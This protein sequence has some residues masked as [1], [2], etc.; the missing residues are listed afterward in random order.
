VKRLENRIDKIMGEAYE[1]ASALIDAEVTKLLQAKP[2]RYDRFVMAV[3]WGP[4]WF[5]PDGKIIDEDDMC[6]KGKKLAAYITEF[7]DRFGGD[8]HQV[9]ITIDTR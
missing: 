1:K 8:N 4:T 5:G 9:C 6:A 2:Q 7:Y 3:G